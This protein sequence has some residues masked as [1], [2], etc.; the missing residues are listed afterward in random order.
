MPNEPLNHL[1]RK[2]ITNSLNLATT[3]LFG[4]LKDDVTEAKK[5]EILKNIAALNIAFYDVN[6]ARVLM[7]GQHEDFLEEMQNLNVVSPSRIPEDNWM[8]S[9]DFE[10]Y[11]NPVAKKPL[12]KYTESM[13]ELTALLDQKLKNP[14]TLGR[15][16]KDFIYMMKGMTESLSRGE[17]LTERYYNHP[18]MSFSANIFTKLYLSNGQILAN[19]E[20][21]SI[22]IEETF[23]GNDDKKVFQNLEDTG[24]VQAA[25]GS[26][27]V[28]EMHERY[29]TKGDVSKE[30]L[31]DE[32]EEQAERLEKAF[33]LEE[34]EFNRLNEG[35]QK[36]FGNDYNDLFG[37]SR[38]YDFA[39]QD[40]KIRA[41]LLKIGYTAED[42]PALSQVFRVINKLEVM[43]EGRTGDVERIKKEIANEEKKENPNQALLESKR[44]AL[45]A[46][47]EEQRKLKSAYDLLNEEWSDTADYP[48]V[49][50][51]TRLERL[52]RLK[53]VTA[54]IGRDY[55][56][57]DKDDI[58]SADYALGRRI[59]SPLKA[60]EKA[61]LA[62]NANQMYEQLCAVDPRL[63]SSSNEFADLKRKLKALRDYEVREESFDTDFET[64]RYRVLAKDVA[65][66]AAKYLRY[67][68][69]ALTFVLA[70]FFVPGFTMPRVGGES[71]FE[72]MV[73]GQTVGRLR[74]GERAQELLLT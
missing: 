1:T 31:I 36:T 33:S 38:G 24:I 17:S 61:E 71:V 27:K 29:V 48:V 37:K 12:E 28:T 9:S 65:E 39:L 73:N 23:P 52:N 49:T 14:N 54:R 46:K 32:Y 72:V 47:E 10:V 66:A 4:V 13:R 8:D 22:T 58:L 15:T 30:E 63:V 60:Y 51:T 45:A 19:P 18:Q 5:K 11:T 74:D 6:Q 40:A 67:K 50:E 25:A 3:A 43:A 62:T 56:V 64:N 7:D 34:E 2:D 35:D 69:A 42:L 21:G 57:T 59:A 16:E 68:T 26:V 55:R 44:N 20:D 41:K 70:L 53:D